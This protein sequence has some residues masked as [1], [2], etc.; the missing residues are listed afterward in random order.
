MGSPLSPVLANLYMEFFEEMAI[1][2]ATHKP[3]LWIRY[4]DDT[5]VI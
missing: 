3:T 2:T 4:V 1:D 5:F